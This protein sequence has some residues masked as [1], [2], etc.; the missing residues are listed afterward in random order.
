MNTPIAARA[1]ETPV[2]NRLH[3]HRLETGAT[4]DAVIEKSATGSSATGKLKV[5][6]ILGASHSGTTLTAMVLGALPDVCTIGELKL[7]HLGDPEHYK[8]SCGTLI[9]ACPFWCNVRNRMAAR[10]Q[11]F[12]V[13]DAGTDIFDMPSAYVRRLLRPL[14]RGPKWE[15]LRDFALSLS[16]AW[17]MGL[18][19]LQHQNAELIRAVCELHGVST[20]V[21]S[22]KTAIRAKYLL[23]ND[24]LDVRIVRLVRDGRGTAHIYILE[25]N[26]PMPAAAMEWKRST[27]EGEAFLEGVDP[28]R[29][30]EVRY[31]ELCRDPAATLARIC[32]FADVPF[33]GEVRCFRSSEH[34]IVGNYMRMETSTT[35]KLDDRWR[36]VFTQKQ[37]DE[38]DAVAGELN[39][40]YG[41]E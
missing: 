26:D 39:R 7:S 20:I 19:R 18:P 36:T 27:L 3:S 35:I 24:A 32:R 25:R 16:S 30:I 29:W 2:E 37:L 17:R 5:I 4:G 33:D 31:E 22:S 15:A 38:F 8:C 28:A 23:K 13:A 40:K 12:D 1:D 6:Y 11:A 9:R 21:D 14:C 41:Y 10:G 34:H